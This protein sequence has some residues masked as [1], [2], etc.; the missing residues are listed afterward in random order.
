[1]KTVVL[2]LLAAERNV[3]EEDMAN[4]LE[5]SRPT[6]RRRFAAGNFRAGEIAATAKLLKMS[7]E[8][9]KYIFFDCE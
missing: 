7:E 4:A 5:I 1:M 6:L 8:E 3:S 2:K 9:I